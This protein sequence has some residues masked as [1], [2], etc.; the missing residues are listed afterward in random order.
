MLTRVKSRI[1]KIAPDLQF[2]GYEGGNVLAAV[3]GVGGFIAF[4]DGLHLLT[5]MSGQNIWLSME[6][7]FIRFPDVLV[8]T[9][10]ATIVLLTIIL[11]RIFD[12][13]KRRPLKTWID[14]LASIIGLGLVFAALYYGA[15]WI[16]F[17]A[18]SFVSASALLR[19]CRISPVFLKLG[20]LMLAAGGVGLVGYGLS[21]VEG[22]GSTLLSGLTVLTGIYVFFASLMTYQGGIFECDDWRN[23]ITGNVSTDPFRPEGPLALLLVSTLDHPISFLVRRVALPAVFWVS[24]QTKATAPF[25][26]SMWTR[27]PWR[28]LTGSAAI[29]TGTSVGFIFGFAN[30]FWAVGDIAI[31]SLDWKGAGS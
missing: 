13:G 22:E 20:G 10:L 17:A 31:G 29:A 5:E 8:S 19:L 24:R 30:L 14:R 3:A 23:S 16:T 12:D 1:N 4:Y 25:L 26:T 15:S 28:L 27:L 11:G 9:G 18:V 2:W 6:A 21:T 7:A